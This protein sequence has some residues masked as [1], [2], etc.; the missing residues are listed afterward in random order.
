MPAV[1]VVIPTYNRAETISRAIDSVLQQTWD[2]FE[3]IIVDDGSTDQTEEI[4]E[5]Y[6]DDRVVYV[7]FHSN[8]GANA[9]RNEGVRHASG[10]LVSFLDSD[11]EFTENH[12]QRV[13][14]VL[15]ESP[16][17]IG[18]VYTS[19]V[20]LENGEKR[21]VD[22]A[23]QK[24]TDPSDV[25]RNYPANGFSSFTFRRSV[26]ELVGML[27]EELDAFQDRE[28]LIRCLAQFDIIPISEVLVKYHTPEGRIST[29]SQKK[30]SALKDIEKLHAT[31]INASGNAYLHYT[32]AILHA[33]SKEM[34]KARHFFIR[35]SMLEIK[36]LKYHAHSVTSLFGYPGYKFARNTKLRIKKIVHRLRDMN[37]N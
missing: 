31:K 29:D 33:E 36:S 21:H 23:K 28:Y 15:S 17:G 6:S 37:I 11:D 12:L 9:A 27:E 19:Q 1:S 34:K 35:A 10:E 24:L 2:D 26:F 16:S 7:Q 3:I 25:I 4:V 22:A 8:K 20:T 14:G 18:G 30:L 13:I 32:R 5:S